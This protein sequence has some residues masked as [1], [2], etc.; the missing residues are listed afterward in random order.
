MACLCTII[1]SNDSDMNFLAKVIIP[2]NI[3]RVMNIRREGSTIVDG[4]IDLLKILKHQA[5]Q[6]IINMFSNKAAQ[7]I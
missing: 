5:K 3:Y 7:N 4:S 1:T 2:T 6:R